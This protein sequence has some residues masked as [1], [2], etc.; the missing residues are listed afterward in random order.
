MDESSYPA[1]LS[2]NT[3]V[4]PPNMLFSTTPRQGVFLSSLLY[5]I[6]P[7]LDKLV[8]GLLPWP[9]LIVAPCELKAHLVAGFSM[10][11][12]TP[13]LICLWPLQVA[14]CRHPPTYRRERC[15]DQSACVDFGLADFSAAA[16]RNGMRDFG[17]CIG[18]P[19][20]IET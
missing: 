15:P 9:V 14:T 13:K 3:T 18:D 20:E 2:S 5:L 12:M 6:N 7:V 1:L 4:R 16:L 8:H 17:D 10:S 19:Y 11:F